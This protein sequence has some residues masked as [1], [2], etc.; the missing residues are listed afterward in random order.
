MS[1][2][3]AEYESASRRSATRTPEL[4]VA[5]A[6]VLMFFFGFCEKSNLR[7]WSYFYAGSLSLLLLGELAFRGGLFDSA[8]QKWLFFSYSAACA[9]TALVLIY[10][11]G[12]S[13]ALMLWLFLLMLSMFAGFL[14]TR[15]QLS[16]DRMIALLIAGGVMLRFV[17]VL[18]TGSDTRQH[19]VGLWTGKQGHAAYIMYWYQNGLKLPDFDVRGLWQFYHPPLHHWLMALSLKLFT[20]CGMIFDTACEALQLLPFLWSCLTMSVCCR[21]FRRVGLDGPP[22]VSAMAIVCF[23]PTFVLLAGSFN[24]DALCVLL[25]LLTVL[26]ALSWYR[27]PT[28]RRILALG[29]SLGLAMMTKLSAWLVSPAVALL[30]LCVLLRRRNEWKGLLLQFVC[31]GLVCAPLGLWWEIRNAVAFGVPLSYIPRLPETSSQ[32]IGQISAAQ[33]LFNFGG[34]QL[35]YVYDA[36][37]S[38]G[39]PYNEFNP[40]VGLFKTA[41]FDEGV[42]TAPPLLSA[43][44]TALFWVGTV[45]G[46][47]CFVAFVLTMA[48]E[49]SGL[50]GQSRA[51]FSVFTLTVLLSYYLFCFAYPYV[52]TMNVRYCVP[53]IPLFAMG[54]GLW[55]KRCSGSRGRPLRRA[56]GG[57]T[58]LFVLMSC[59]MYS[60]IG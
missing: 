27:K 37:T 34:G 20:G 16:T 60:M 11:N 56:V 23:H 36:F 28:L 2:P 58:V 59:L 47:L 1:H 38:H 12:Q 17:Y 43:A 4:C 35:S 32:H 33:R 54:L 26:L 5:L 40:T 51:F 7:L 8:R 44:G 45:C 42:Y 24:N 22:L 55:L 53:L 3:I 29:L 9:G 14:H 41:L 19:D 48:R 6:C 52:C 30:F 18:Y 57:L 25:T 50:D 31:F 15:G 46:L 13:T 21:I 49:D 39:A 10:T